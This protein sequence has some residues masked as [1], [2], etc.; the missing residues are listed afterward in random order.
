MK[1]VYVFALVTD[2]C[3][4]GSFEEGD[5]IFVNRYF[6]NDISGDSMFDVKWEETYVEDGCYRIISDEEAKKMGANVDF[7]RRVRPYPK[8]IREE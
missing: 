4:V 7:M 3:P 1:K 5:I 6:N 8:E 2:D